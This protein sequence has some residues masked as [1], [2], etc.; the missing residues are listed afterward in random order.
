MQKTFGI[1]EAA[2]LGINVKKLVLKHM[3]YASKEEVERKAK[4]YGRKKENG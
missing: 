2:F 1:C 4:D 3:N